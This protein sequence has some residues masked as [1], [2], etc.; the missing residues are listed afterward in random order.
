MEKP[1][2]SAELKLGKYTKRAARSALTQLTEM[3]LTS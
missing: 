2:T 1:E 3:S